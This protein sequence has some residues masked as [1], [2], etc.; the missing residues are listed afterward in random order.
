MFVVASDIDRCLFSSGDQASSPPAKVEE[1]KTSLSNGSK[2]HE[3]GISS[4]SN[5]PVQTKATIEDTESSQRPSNPVVPQS[6]KTTPEI[7][8]SVIHSPAKTDSQAETPRRSQK[9][10]IREVKDINSSALSLEAH[11][12][13]K[14]NRVRTQPYQSPLPELALIVKTLNKSPS[15]KAADDKLIVFYK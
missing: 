1:K 9:R 11:E 14:R 8:P 13:P 10:K 4:S 5:T 3:E 7:S 2:E 15:S 6:S 12:K